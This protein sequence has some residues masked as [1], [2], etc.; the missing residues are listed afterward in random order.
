M[1]CNCNKPNIL[2]SSATG[3]VSTDV[4]LLTPTTALSPIDEQKVMIKVTTATPTAGQ[5]LPVN[6]VFNGANVPV[7]DKFGNVMYGNE[8]YSGMILK[9]YFGD[10]EAHYLVINYPNRR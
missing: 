5:I 6:I 1:A 3:A 8:L 2:R 10:N 7:L 9:G 4:L